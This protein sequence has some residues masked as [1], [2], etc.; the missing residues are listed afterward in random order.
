EGIVD[1]LDNE[2]GD[3]TNS[4]YIQNAI[5]RENFQRN[6]LIKGL[7]EAEKN[8]FILISDLDE[9]PN[10][11][12]IDLSKI[13]NKL[14][15]F[16]QKNFYYKFNLY[17]DNLEW[18]GSKGCKFKNLESPQWL[19][20]IKGKKYSFL[21]LD[22]LFSKN[23]YQNIKLIEDGGWHFS[24]LKDAKGIEEKLK[25]YLHH[26]EY[27]ME[28]LGID[29]INQMIKSN[30]PV[31][32]LKTDKLKSKFTFSDQLKTAK[33]EELPDYVQKNIEKYNQW[34]A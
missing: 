23:K 16:K 33:N 25:S 14:V 21:R 8:D 1:I 28:P 12:K 9:I 34:F 29:R 22:T 19:R 5:K 4:K 17:I 15:F 31:Y 24:Y 18:Y 13:K 6:C 32:N 26:R 2:R 3:K 20:N 10:L 11:K 30:M 7:S 27:D